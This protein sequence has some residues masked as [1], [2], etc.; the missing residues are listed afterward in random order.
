MLYTGWLVDGTQFDSNQDAA[1]P[2]S[3]E[4]GSGYV[5]DGFDEGITGM[6]VGGVRKLVMPSSLA[7]GIGGFPPRIPGEATLVFDVELMEVVP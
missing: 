2:L 3:F 7:Y 1:N 6:K 5:I 4:L